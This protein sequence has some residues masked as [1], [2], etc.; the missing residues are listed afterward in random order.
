MKN[1]VFNPIF[2]GNEYVPDGEP[3]VF[4]DRVY[5]YGSH[6]RF[7]GKQFCM[8][9][10]TVWSAP[11]NDLSDW[12]NHGI[13][14]RK[15]QDPHSGENV[16]MF[17]PDCVQGSD[18]KFYL[19]YQQSLMPFVSVAVSDRPEGPFEYYGVVKYPDGT[20]A[21]TR[22]NDVFMFDPAVFRDDDGEIYLYCGFSPDPAKD[23]VFAQAM[24]KYRMDG[25]Y[26]FS[27]EK[28]ML[29]ITK[30][31]GR[32]YDSDFF[33]ASSIRKFDGRYYFIYSSK[34]KHELKWVVSDSPVT[35]FASGG[36]LVSNGDL[37]LSKKRLNYTGNNHGSVECINGKYYVFYHRQTNKTN[38][39]RQACAEEITFHDGV[40]EQAEITSCGL[41]GGPL[42]GEGT[43][44]ARIACNLWS[45]TGAVEYGN[46]GTP[47]IEDHPY[48][49]QS[50]EGV[51]YIANMRE[52]ATAVF[53]YFDITPGTTIT[54][55]HTGSGEMEIRQENGVITF[56]YHGTDAA[57]FY[58]FSFVRR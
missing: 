48:F 43:Y 18:G 42:V 53:K 3:H 47:G 38:F 55:K 57:D 27:L 19:Y 58:S 54:A 25:S 4:G 33:E 29:T 15:S 34:E 35:G 31:H 8:E 14:Y 11:V 30:E 39:S 50:A 9:D 22:E 52:G 56:V 36:I 7:N 17:A 45:K 5:L 44:P 20:A 46:A 49:T 16:F 26:A 40:F 10:Y 32:V 12:K 6:D 24:K 1:Q 41:N 28:D 13:S 2:P 21:G 23:P 37:G 51:Q